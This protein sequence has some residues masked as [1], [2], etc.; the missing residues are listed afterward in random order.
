MNTQLHSEYSRVFS[1]EL[2]AI[3]CSTD[4]QFVTL[5]TVNARGHGSNSQ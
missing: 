3:S 2:C 1:A 5:K 4:G